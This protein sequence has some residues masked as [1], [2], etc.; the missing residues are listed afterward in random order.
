MAYL[1]VP[2]TLRD[3]ISNYKSLS[4]KMVTKLAALSKDKEILDILILLAPKISD[5]SVTTTTLEK[6]I[7]SYLVPGVK[8]NKF[9]NTELEGHDTS[10]KLLFK[11]RLQ[12]SGEIAVQIS[13]QIVDQHHMDV[14]HAQFE[15][16]LRG[17][18]NR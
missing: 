5:Q 14:L 13:K 12:N 8:K 15:H 18:L 1:R 7:Q 16:F 11:T 6:H 9:V 3:A 4:K 17:F 10:G 2:E